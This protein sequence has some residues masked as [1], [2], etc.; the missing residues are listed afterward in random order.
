[1]LLRIATVIWITRLKCVWVFFQRKRMGQIGIYVTTSLAATNKNYLD[2]LVIQF[3]PWL[4]HHHHHLP[5]TW[6]VEVTLWCMNVWVGSI[7]VWNTEN[8]ICRQS[9]NSCQGCCELFSNTLAKR[10][11]SISPWKNKTRKTATQTGFISLGIVTSLGGRDLN[12]N[13]PSVHHEMA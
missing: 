5:Y 8:G 12:S 1:M 6:S 7:T 10:H 2:S 9:S 4:Y 13:S 11:E 3:L